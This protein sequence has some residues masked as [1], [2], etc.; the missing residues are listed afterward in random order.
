LSQRGDVA[1]VAKVV[2]FGL[3]K[4]IAGEA[5][6]QTRAVMGTPAYLAPETMTDP[7]N[8]GPATDLYALGA[9]GYFLLTGKLVFQGAT[10][11]DMCI[12]HVTAI[13]VPPSQVTTVEVPR[14]LEE[15]ILQC[16]AKNPSDRPASAQELAR[17]LREV[18]VGSWAE[19]D[20][21]QWWGQFRKH[22]ASRGTP[23]TGS[24]TI[25]LGIRL[26]NVVAS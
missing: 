22:A 17:R 16:L 18:P 12:K 7:D 23:A 14:Q 6:G 26:P 20:A 9:V 19:Q 5:T 15:L 24:I 8:I 3:A 13:P 25:D 21:E 2:D 4:E 10:T 1:D 11:V